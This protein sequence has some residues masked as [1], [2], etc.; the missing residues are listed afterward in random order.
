[1]QPNAEQLAEITELAASGKLK[2]HVETV[3]PFS[4]IVKAHELSEAGKSRGK[5]V[6]TMEN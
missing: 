1:M 2:T 6:L 3:L 5:I 4:E